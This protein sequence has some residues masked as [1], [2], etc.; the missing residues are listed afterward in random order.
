MVKNL[1]AVILLTVISFAVT[2][3]GNGEIIEEREALPVLSAETAY[4]SAPVSLPSPTPAPLPPYSPIVEYDEPI[5][6]L[7]IFENG[8]LGMKFSIENHPTWNFQAGHVTNVNESMLAHRSCVY[9]NISFE[10]AQGTAHPSE[11]WGLFYRPAYHGWGRVLWRQ[12][13][14]P[15]EVFVTDNGLTVVKYTHVTERWFGLIDEG[16]EFVITLFIFRRDGRDYREISNRQILYIAMLSAH[17]NDYKEL[18]DDARKVLN[19]LQ[20][21]DDAAISLEPRE[22]VHA[23]GIT[24]YNW[25]RI[26]GST[27][28]I[29][30]MNRLVNNM[31]YPEITSRGWTTFQPYEFWRLSRTIPSYELLIWGYTDIIFVPEPSAYVLA[32]I[33]EAGVEL[34][35]IP[36]ALEALAFITSVENP[37]SELTTRQILQ[38]YSEMSLTNW[39]ALGGYDGR[40]IP[41]NRNPHSGSQ[42]LMENLVMRGQAFHPGLSQYIIWEMQTMIDSTAEHI[43]EFALGYT[44]Y[45]Y[46]SVMEHLA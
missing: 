39:S 30:F 17:A 36:F 3:C 21:L 1:S 32:L 24:A 11:W 35:F 29:P 8:L 10:I 38:I 2:A 23:M 33:E 13:D 4:E 37:V 14:E 6:P 34:E 22:S 25:P 42:S 46:L 31:F 16:D 7:I 45:F 40:I 5:E 27:S 9:G 28:M 15:E 43:E 20:F 19:S 41:L 44:V 18:Y 12:P 26:D